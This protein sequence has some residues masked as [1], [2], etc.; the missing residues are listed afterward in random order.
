MAM[1][2]LPSSSVMDRS[3]WVYELRS[4]Y[5]IIGDLRIKTRQVNHRRV[6][7]MRGTAAIDFSK[8]RLC[9]RPA[10]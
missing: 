2:D 10:S 5:E 8:A 4:M 7:Q 9:S 3:F 1:A 6:Q